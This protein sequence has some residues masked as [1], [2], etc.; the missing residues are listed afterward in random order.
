MI[1]KYVFFIYFFCFSTIVFSQAQLPYDEIVNND[2]EIRESYKLIYK[3]FKN[4]SEERLNAIE[5]ASEKDFS[6]DNSLRALPRVLTENEGDLIDKGVR[7]RAE[8][9]RMF[10]EEYHSGGTSWQKVI[11]KRV[12]EKIIERNGEASWKGYV[13]PKDIEFW[14]GPDIIRGPD[15]KFYVIED[16]PG[17]IGGM[18]DLIQARE[19][20]EKNIPEYYLLNSPHPS[21][22]YDKLAEKHVLEAKK[23]NGV[24][25]LLSY[26]PKLAADKEDDRLIEILEDRGV[27]SVRNDAWSKNK[28]LA[29]RKLVV[30]KDGVWLHIKKKK[31]KTKK[32]KVGSI[33]LNMEVLDVDPGFIANRHKRLLV[34]ASDT[35]AEKGVSKFERKEI[36]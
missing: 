18:G 30:K 14:Y 26:A 4:L 34:E 21:N 10:V 32:L 8:A 5:K 15:G 7:Q 16:N 33:I 12:L 25:V 31:R 27:Y 11:P 2:G 19:T 23:N 17:F 3:I 9:I 20:I 36:K 6:G 1:I 35:L 29:K 22:F 24:A 13:R 28:S